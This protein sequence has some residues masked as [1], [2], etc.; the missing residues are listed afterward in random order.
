MEDGVFLGPHVLLLNDKLPRA[1]N[2]D[3]TPKSA[4]DWIVSG[5]T[6]RQGASIGGRATLLPGVTVGRWALVGA[7]AVVTTDVPDYALVFG[8][9]ARVHGYVDRAGKRMSATSRAGGE[10]VYTSPDG[11]SVVVASQSK[12]RANST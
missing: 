1:V 5:V 4:T 7:G 3:G 10:V 11:T 6:V 9:P 2:P 8:N 12:A